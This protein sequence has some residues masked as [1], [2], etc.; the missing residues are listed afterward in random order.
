MANKVEIIELIANKYHLP[1]SQV[2]RAIHAQF[3][4]A[5]QFMERDSMPTV[6]L[7]YY[8]KFIV[9]KKTLNYINK[10]NAKRIKADQQSQKDK[11]ES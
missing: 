4:Y 7:P 1:K 11:K 8:G 6:R 9:N 5:K 3:K 10:A 2:E